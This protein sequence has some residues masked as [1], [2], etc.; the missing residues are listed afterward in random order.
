MP[1]IVFCNVGPRDVQLDGAVSKLAAREAGQLWIEQFDT[2]YERLSLPIIRAALEYV[3]RQEGRIDQLIFFGTDQENEIYRPSD[4]LHFAALIARLLGQQESRIG[5][6]EVALVGSNPPIDP[7]LYD[8]AFSAYGEKMR[9]LAEEEKSCYVLTTGGLPACNTALILQ[10]IGLFADRCHVIYTSSN[11]EPW[12]LQIGHQV[13]GIMRKAAAIELLGNFDFAAASRLLNYNGLADE[14]TK[15]LLAY[16]NARINFDFE[17]ARDHL[18]GAIAKS[19][20]ELRQRLQETR[21]GLERLINQE[22][23]A[24]IAELYHNARITWDNGH[25]VGYLSRLIRFQE[26]VLRH[27]ITRFLVDSAPQTEKIIDGIA[28]HPELRH[29]LLSMLEHMA[30]R[31][32]PRVDLYSDTET[33]RLLRENMIAHFSLSELQDLCFDLGI[34]DENL[35]GLTKGDKVRELIEYA[36]RTDHLVELV[37]ACRMRRPAVQWGQRIESAVTSPG[38]LRA[39]CASL[40]RLDSLVSL[41]NDSIIGHGYGGISAEIIEAHYRLMPSTPIQDMALICGVIDIALINPFRDVRDMIT[42]LLRSG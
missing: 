22:E 11:A 23:L 25:Y 31:E 18:E 34:D 10:S 32:P 38:N 15:C 24:R 36:R 35:A 9:P 4:T 26:A 29:F 27:L 39:A 7:T 20:G 2:L 30:E 28:I 41:R 5:C 17:G 37:D 40:R 14:L 19:R 33:L 8:E 13:T 3:L 16:A 42:G 1:T 6:I 12:P 21:K